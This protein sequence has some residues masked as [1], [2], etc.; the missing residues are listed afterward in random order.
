MTH[1]ALQPTRIRGRVT[2][3]GGQPVVGVKV[4]LRGDTDIVLT[5]DDGRYVLAAIVAGKPTIEVT[6][7]TFR[8]FSQ[9]LSLAAGQER[10]VDVV[11]SPV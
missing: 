5:D 7:K 11:L 1:I 10:I 4:R 8:P 9:A 2:R 3:N 6:A